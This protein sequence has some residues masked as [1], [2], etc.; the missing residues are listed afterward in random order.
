[1]KTA[2]MTTQW[3]LGAIALAAALTLSAAPIAHAHGGGGGGGGGGGHGGGGGGGGHG[4]GGHGGGYGGGHGGHGGWGGYGGH[5]GFGGRGYGY[6]RYGYGYGGFGYGGFGYGGFGLLGYGLFF[7][8]L[9]LYYSTYWW[10]GAPYYYAND[11]FY[12]WNGSVSQYE[13]VR[14]PQNLANQAAQGRENFNLFA[15][16]KNGQTTERQATD[17]SECQQWATGQ[18]GI[19]SPPADSTPAIAVTAAKR[20]DYLRAQSACLEGRGY[21]VQ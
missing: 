21:S 19:D 9:P 10:G 15:Y 2:A 16:P 11:N 7:D 20:Q 5:R 18:T 1:M 3:R 12:Q 4:G 8:T 17:R 14:P 13:T 6:G